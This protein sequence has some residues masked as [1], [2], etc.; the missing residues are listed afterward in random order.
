MPTLP[1]IVTITSAPAD[2]VSRVTISAGYDL[3]GQLKSAGTAT[4]DAKGGTFSGVIESDPLGGFPTK[5]LIDISVDYMPES[6]LTGFSKEFTQPVSAAGVHFFYDVPKQLDR[7][8]LVGFGFVP[9]STDRLTFRW[10]HLVKGAPVR[11]DTLEVTAQQVAGVWQAKPPNILVALKAHPEKDN[12]LQIRIVAITEF[13]N[14][15]LE[16]FEQTFPVEAQS[17][18]LKSG[19]GAAPRTKKLTAQSF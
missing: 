4:F 2:L 1:L 16:P 13:Q 3:Q 7:Q 18:V 12:R 5:A 17:V 14:E 6:G 10:D 19:P 8:I 11:G 9:S 15:Q